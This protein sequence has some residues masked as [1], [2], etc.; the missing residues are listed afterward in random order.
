MTQL[1]DVSPYLAF[2]RRRWWLLILLPLLYAAVA[3]GLSLRAAPVYRA[4]ALLQVSPA[5]PA[6]ADVSA[7]YAG[8]RLAT[9]YAEIIGQPATLEATTAQLATVDPARNWQFTVEAEPIRETQLIR[10]QV[11]AASP[12]DAE[13]IANTL[14]ATFIAANQARQVARFAA[15]KAN[16]E[17]Q[18]AASET[19]I[20][21]EEAGAANA[22]V[23][24]RLR[25]SLS[26]LTASYEGIR[27]A[28]AQSAD[29]ITVVQPATASPNPVRPRPLF[30]ALAAAIVGLAMALALAFVLEALDDRL[31]TAERAAA[32]TSL[33]VLATVTRGPAANGSGPVIL[34]DP[35]ASGAEAYR[36][37][38][39]NL[40]F[41]ALDHPLRSVTVV[42]PEPG[43]GKSTTAANLAAAMAQ[44]GQRVILVDAD[45]RRPTLHQMFGVGNNV[46]LTT[47][48]LDTGSELSQHLQV[49]ALPNLALL[50]SGP[51][52]PNPS[53]LL[54]SSRMST[55]LHEMST[56]ADAV[57]LD[58]AP[59]LAVADAAIL[60]HLSD[61]TLLVIDATRTR[62]GTAQRAA[63]Q[64]QRTG[65]HVLGVVLNRVARSENAYDRYYGERSSE[66]LA[67]PHRPTQRPG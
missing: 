64:L 5:A 55:L 11:D 9:T 25:Q 13:T 58:S 3:Y 17:E 19:Q 31:H 42:S 54:S 15:S 45:L 59:V 35:Q 61:G 39:A 12:A 33:P 29:N 26:A 1:P 14:A 49:T 60:A 24:A 8:E 37:L 32:A 43:E 67:V 48:L 40:R 4:Q 6:T 2:L 18:I 44:T 28:E 50:T 36:V 46:G 53:E 10:L 21:A 22:D 66:T 51:L 65:A 63:A 62:R 38:R 23:L 27:L 56:Q 47:A 7:I 57:I 16:L 41:A 30:N 52:P 34:Q 20:K